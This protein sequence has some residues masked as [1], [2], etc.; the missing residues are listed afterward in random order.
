MDENNMLDI[1]I[2]IDFNFDTYDTCLLIGEDNIDEYISV[3]TIIEIENDDPCE[4]EVF[5]HP[6]FKCY[7]INRECFD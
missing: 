5:Q 6:I 7:Y 4:Y 1:S 2:N 3:D